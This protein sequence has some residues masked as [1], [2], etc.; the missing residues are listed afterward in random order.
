[1]IILRI[2]LIFLTTILIGFCGFTSEVKVVKAQD[3]WRLIVDGK[4]YF[5]KGVCYNAD[6][7]GESPNEGTLRNWMFVDDDNDGRNDPAYQSWVDKNKNNRRDPGENEIGDFKLLKK[8][9]CNTIRVY[10]HASADPEIH[11]IL[12]NGA[13]AQLLY[14]RAPNK[15]LLRDLY[16]NYGIMVAM[17]DLVGA[18][19]VGSGADWK[20]GTDYRDPLQK[21]RMLKCVKDM[22]LE[23]KDEPYILFW[24]LGNE[25]NYA[26]NHTKAAQYPEAY[27]QFI[28]EAAQMVHKLDPSHPVCLCNGDI[29]LLQFYT[30]LAPEVDIFGVNI[31]RD[32]GFSALWESVDQ[33][34]NKPVVITEYG[35]GYPGVKNGILDEDKQLRIHRKCWLD[36]AGHRA[37][38]AFP[39]NTLGGFIYCWMDDWWQ[40]GFPGVHNT[41]PDGSGWDHE[42][43][44]LMSQGNGKNSPLMR[45]PRKVYFEYQKL[46]SE[47]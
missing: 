13:S 7:V 25:N 15:D 26:F 36:I 39:G 44:G 42:Y 23:F 33:K 43:N 24:V 3:G 37:G 27:A 5:V 11:K 9:G 20:T 34:Y 10:H 16:K 47:N 19:C 8:M 2:F 40:D 18:Y 14:N 17:G 21:Q 6:K 12:S 38:K 46:W 45:Q 4:A 32:Y 1:M 35:M 28:N 30:K 31:Y 22:V 29:L 41:N